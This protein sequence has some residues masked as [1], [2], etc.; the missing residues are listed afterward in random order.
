MVY[1]APKSKAPLFVPPRNPWKSRCWHCGYEC[2]SVM[3]LQDANTVVQP[4]DGDLALCGECSAPGIFDSTMP[5]GVRKPSPRE[6]DE[7]EAQLGAT[8]NGNR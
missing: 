2:D 1:R 5:D 6:M 8:F 3:F 4:R 7:I